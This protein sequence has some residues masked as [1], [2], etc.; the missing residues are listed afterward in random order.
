MCRVITRHRD[1]SGHSEC[2]GAGDGR[3]RSISTRLQ[4]EAGTAAATVQKRG[5]G[6]EARGA[7]ISMII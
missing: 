6:G 2:D 4:F 5:S 1:A 3:H 7:F